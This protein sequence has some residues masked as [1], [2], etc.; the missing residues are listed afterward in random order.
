MA[1]EKKTKERP[2]KKPAKKAGGRRPRRWGGRLLRWLAH[3]SASGAG[4]AILGALAVVVMA[5][6]PA[7]RMTLLRGFIVP[8]LSAGGVHV[9]W[10]KIET[11]DAR[12][13][14]L[15]EL[16]IAI[17]EAHVKLSVKDAAAE[18][19]YHALLLGRLGVPGVTL[20]GISSGDAPPEA[21][22]AKT[23]F[24][25]LGV[26]DMAGQGTDLKISTKDV[27]LQLLA[28]LGGFPV[29]ENLGGTLNGD[30][31]LVGDGVNVNGL[32]L[33]LKDKRVQPVIRG[34]ARSAEIGTVTLAG[35]YGPQ[36]FD[37]NLKTEKLSAALLQL[38]DIGISSG[39]MGADIALKGTAEHPLLSG[40]FSYDE[41]PHRRRAAIRLAGKIATENDI[42][43]VDTA[44]S[45]SGGKAGGALRLAVPLTGKLSAKLS[46]RLD[47]SFL[48]F[49]LDPFE[50]K[51]S[52]ALTLDLAVSGDRAHPALNGTLAIAKGFYDNVVSG[53]TLSDINIL[54]R[55]SGQKIAIEKAQAG[56]GAKGRMSLSG[57]FD[58]ADKPLTRTPVSLTFTAEHAQLLRRRDMSGSATGA[59]RLAGT[60]KGMTLSG[61]LEVSPFTMSLDALKASSIPEIEVTDATPGARAEAGTDGRDMMALLPPVMTDV[62]IN[63]SKQ[64]YL[65]GMGVDA[66]VSGHV[67]VGGPLAQSDYSG[68]FKTVRGSCE[69][70]GKKFVLQQGQV[71]FEGEAMSLNI[72]ALHHG[73]GVDTTATISGSMKKPA[74]ALT[75]VPAMPQDE[76]LSNLL[77]GK[78]AST[79]TPFQ[80]VRLA[81]AVQ[82]MRGG[83]AGIFD[84]VGSVR[85]K[86]GLDSLS[87]GSDSTPDGQQGFSAGAGKYIGDKVY[88]EVQ[89]TPDPTHPFEADVQVELTPHLNLKSGSGGP[90]GAGNI[91]L[92]WKK[93]Y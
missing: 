90:T 52:G 7:G 73:Q 21:L 43:T 36:G 62:T 82:Q 13:W 67:H 27:P 9:S 14:H 8:V 26:L 38:M 34:K 6:T 84:P 24:T 15:T 50:H 55:A 60:L 47:L 3:L 31:S 85:D 86:L 87:V 1:K 79:L 42:V 61:T 59:L 4:F 11:P 64:A 53:T 48:R 74:L 49:V 81:A 71:D 78:S 75:S 12:H 66:E 70:F 72:S 23:V 40:G 58:W 45:Q 68:S 41:R 69:V 83:G 19:D 5:G 17:P 80:A 44:L 16:K 18:F 54:L 39:T 65:R 89:K 93:D 10:Q 22:A 37:M 2:E 20:K 91:G 28:A 25:A 77:F 32:T 35:L 33:A 29:P 63:V 57:A 51:L 56:D 76:I 88:L 92:Q 30:V 46:G